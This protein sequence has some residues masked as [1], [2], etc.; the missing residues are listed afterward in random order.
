MEQPQSG[1]RNKSEGVP[2]E[3]K[4]NCC[5]WLSSLRIVVPLIVAILVHAYQSYRINDAADHEYKTDYDLV[6]R[7]DVKVL[8]CGKGVYTKQSPCSWSQIAATKTPA[9]L[10]NSVC[11]AWAAT[12]KWDNMT[13]LSTKLA[14]FTLTD[15]YQQQADRFAFMNYDSN[16]RLASILVNHTFRRHEILNMSAA[17]FFTL[18]DNESI[19]TDEPHRNRSGFRYWAGPIPEALRSDVSPF[20]EEHLYPTVDVKRIGMW[21][22]SPGVLATLHYDTYHNCFVQVAGQKRVV[23]FPPDIHHSVHL[24]PSLHPGYRQSQRLYSDYMVPRNASCSIASTVQTVPLAYYDFVAEPGDIV[25]I[26]PFWF[27]ATQALTYSASVNVWTYDALLENAEQIFVDPIPF[28][29]TWAAPVQTTALVVYLR[30]FL[31]PLVFDRKQSSPRFFRSFVRNWVE[32]RYK[33]L[34][35]S[36]PEKYGTHPFLTAQT[37]ASFGKLGFCAKDSWQPSEHINERFHAGALAVA[38]RLHPLS[39]P[40]RTIFLQDL[41]EE[42]ISHF[43]G[44]LHVITFVNTCLLSSS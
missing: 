14:L 16:A 29:D 3:S 15:V 36:L 26:P 40:I 25:Y 8:D 27:H 17:D 19:A 11:T 18:V 12:E 31:V 2:A 7:S 6:H 34:M 5:H 4:N 44:P 28:D 10:K 13:Y 37:P 35:Q 22:S 20:Q 43:A 21:L 42:M 33:P 1:S 41:I 30:D 24:Y 38:R 9:L 32:A 39:K 23:L